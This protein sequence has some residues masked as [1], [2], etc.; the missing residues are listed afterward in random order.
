MRALKERNPFW[1]GVIATAVTVVAV[2]LAVSVGTLGLGKAR[3]TAEFA[4]TGGLRVGDEVRVAGMGV[5]EVTGTELAGD[6]VLVSFRLDR[7][8]WLGRDTG[9]TIKLATLLGGRYVELRPAGTAALPD[10]NIPLAHTSVPYDLQKVLQTGT[11]LLEDLDAPR[12]RQALD[13]VSANLRGNG[14]KITAALDGLTRL[15]DVVTKRR[16]QL[17]HLVAST[18]QVTELL[19]RRSTQI[20]SLMGQSDT[21]LRALLAR[22]EL[23]RGL[24][25]DAASLTDQLRGLLA[26]NEGQIR[27]LLDNAAEL[28]DVLRRYDD[29]VD[30]ALELLAPAGRYLNNSL[31]NGPYWDVYL[32]YS[33]V[34][35]NIICRT[36]QVPGCR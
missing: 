15:S 34:P 9:A 8:V 35:D 20:V 10:E 27:P 21:L 26:E 2:V 6:R 22:R 11:P 16:E 17:S 4:H 12:F 31:G 19:D 30:R 33:I 13:S 1:V 18:D 14:Q 5:G 23:I 32:P 29:D 25:A 28:T 3:Y 24:L 7:G 36:G